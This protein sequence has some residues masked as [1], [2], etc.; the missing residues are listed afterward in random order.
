MDAKIIELVMGL[1]VSFFAAEASSRRHEAQESLGQVAHHFPVRMFTTQSTR[2]SD[3]PHFESVLPCSDGIVVV[4]HSQPSAKRVIQ[5]RDEFELEVKMQIDSEPLGRGAVDVSL[6]GK[7]LAYCD[8]ESRSIVLFDLKK[9]AGVWCWRLPYESHRRETVV[10]S[11]SADSTRLLIAGNRPAPELKT[12][13]LYWIS[14]DDGRQLDHVQIHGR[15]ILQVV[16]FPF[17]NIFGLLSDRTFVQLLV[18]DDQLVVPERILNDDRNRLRSRRD[19]R[20]IL[21]DGRLFFVAGGGFPAAFNRDGT[22]F[23]AV[24]EIVV[25]FDAVRNRVDHHELMVWDVPSGEVIGKARFFEPPFSIDMRL[26]FADEF[27]EAFA[28]RLHRHPQEILVRAVD[29]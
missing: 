10:V 28:R 9:G 13:E 20:G 12:T 26:H 22:L 17:S 15:D 24:V 7:W 25:P 21:D 19:E 11:F 29:E 4:W 27:D 1:V 2:S 14:V 8:R 16:K 23:A 5:L 6:N 3:W 18:R